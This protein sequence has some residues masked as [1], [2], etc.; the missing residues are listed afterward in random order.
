MATPG[1]DALNRAVAERHLVP[2]YERLAETTATLDQ[3]MQT[4]CATAPGDRGQVLL[5]AYADAFLA[6]QGI[7]HLRFGPIQ[8]L[9][10]DFRFQLWPDKRGSVGKHLRRLLAE[11]DPSRLEADTFAGG[12]AAV[13]GFGALERLLYPGNAPADGDEAAWRCRVATAITANLARM[14]GDTLAGW[15]DGDEAHQMMFATASGG[16][17]YY[18]DERELGAKLLNNLHTQLER[19][20]DQKLA[21]P[22]GDSL[23]KARPKRA[24]AWRSGLSLAAIRVNIE[25]LE[26]LYALGFAPALTDTALRERI[27]A[28]FRRA[29]DQAAQIEQPLAEAVRDPGSRARLEALAATVAGLKGLVA[30][31]LA[32]TL[33]L[34]LGFNS[35]DGD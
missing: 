5:E 15:R 33:E 1:P 25:A 28:A 24:E 29:A 12:S 8:V 7:Q 10:R 30:G 20:V 16:N 19:V 11:R 13:Q 34:P 17:A 2:A 32:R 35:L 22:L 4:Q 14:A 3:R 18:D 6:W 21:R 23:E 26:A 31:D 9:S 27:A